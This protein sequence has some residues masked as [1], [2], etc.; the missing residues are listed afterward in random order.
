MNA[1]LK[2]H[3][4]THGLIILGFLLIT[5]LVHYPSILGDKQIDQHQCH[6]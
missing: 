5:V 6:A 2:K 3:I 1:D 4:L